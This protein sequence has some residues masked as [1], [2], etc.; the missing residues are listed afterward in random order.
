MMGDLSLFGSESLGI[1][2]V[3]DPTRTYR[4]VWSYEL[5]DPNKRLMFS[6]LNPSKADEYRFD[7]T[8]KKWI[9]WTRAWGFGALDVVNAFALRSTDPKAL[10]VAAREG[11][12]PVGPE[13]D[14]YIVEVAARASLRVAGWGK[15][16][17][18]LNR[19]SRMKELLKD[20]E[21]YCMGVNQDGSPVHPLYVANAMR[22]V[23][24]RAHG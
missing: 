20:F 13:N 16:A 1:H 11:G 15:H 6:G 4:Y 19:G 14:R 22:P 9:A 24:W 2:C 5:G 10:Y 23:R 17:A 21:L 18:L 12:D 3:F 7:N 8:V